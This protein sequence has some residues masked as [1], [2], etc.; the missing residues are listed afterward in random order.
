M[1]AA[2]GDVGAFLQ[3]DVRFHQATFEVLSG[4]DAARAAKVMERHFAAAMAA[5]VFICLRYSDNG[6]KP[7]GSPVVDTRIS[8]SLVK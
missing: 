7:P 8:A 3:G 6:I 5:S 2:L 1:G 4:K